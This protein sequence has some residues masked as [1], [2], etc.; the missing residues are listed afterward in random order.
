MYIYVIYIKKNAN[1]CINAHTLKSPK[2]QESRDVSRCAFI[3][4]IFFSSHR[5]FTCVCMIS[6]RKWNESRNKKKKRIKT[7]NIIII[8]KTYVKSSRD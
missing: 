7:Y 6:V 1:T 5:T 3:R 8:M 4:V 2:Y